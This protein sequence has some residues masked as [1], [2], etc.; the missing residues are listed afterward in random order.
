V[1]GFINIVILSALRRS[2]D[3]KATTTPTTLAPVEAGGESPGSAL[4]RIATLLDEVEREREQEAKTEA[5]LRRQR[6]TAH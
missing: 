2:K 1:I 6:R 4:D 3:I 5:E